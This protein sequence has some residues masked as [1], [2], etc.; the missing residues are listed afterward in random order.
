M[1]KVQ[2]SFAAPPLHE[3]AVMRR[4]NRFYTRRI[5]VLDE[6]HLNTDFSLAEVRVIYE[7]ANR[8]SPT[9][10]DLAADLGLDRGYLSRMLTR[11]QRLKLIS[12]APSPHDGRQR[13]L[14][15]TAKGRAKFADLNA[16][17]RSAI[18]A[19]IA[20]LGDADRRRLVGSMNAIE[21]VLA[22]APARQERAVVLRAPRPGDLGWVVQRHGAIYA[23]EFGWTG[24]FEGLV[25]RV[26]ADFTAKFDPKREQCWIA[27][28][29]GENAGSIFLVKHPER[30]GVAQLRLL[31]VEPS[32]RGLG[33]GRRL[34]EECVRF[35]KEAGYRTVTLWTQSALVSARRIYQ[36]AGFKLVSEE[37]HRRFGPGLVGQTWE[38]ALGT[39]GS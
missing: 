20:P 26:V 3:I 14:Q 34:V 33:V 7:L 16:R 39:K 8:E 5:G 35:A 6:G 1:T 38:L 36:A 18:D 27:E 31:L 24:E 28:C 37:K 11:F 9:A 32:A 21:S 13:P 25:A 22:G 10:S 23:E 30:A 2:Q 17:A 15:L 29:D 19:L 4:F 12:R